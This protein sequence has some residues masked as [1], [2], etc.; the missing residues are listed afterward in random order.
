MVLVHPSTQTAHE[1]RDSTAIDMEHTPI[2]MEQ[3]NRIMGQ[4]FTEIEQLRRERDCLRSALADAGFSLRV[5]T[6]AR[7]TDH[8]C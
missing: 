8:A 2:D 4:L 7:C 6:I 5:E 1:D 3:S